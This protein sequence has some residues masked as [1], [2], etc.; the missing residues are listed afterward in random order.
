MFYPNAED[1]IL[2]RIE[3]NESEGVQ[4]LYRE[5]VRF[6]TNTLFSLP[7]HL[8]VGCTSLNSDV[9]NG[10]VYLQNLL[11]ADSTSDFPYRFLSRMEPVE[12]IITL[13]TVCQFVTA[14]Y[15]PDNVERLD[16]TIGGDTFSWFADYDTRTLQ[17][18]LDAEKGQMD[19]LRRELRQLP[20]L[21]ANVTFVGNPKSITI[22]GASYSRVEMVYPFLYVASAVYH[23]IELRTSPSEILFVECAD[24][25]FVD[26]MLN[27]D[28]PRMFMIV[29]HKRKRLQPAFNIS[30]M[31]GRR[32]V[33][34]V[35]QELQLLNILD[36]RC[37]YKDKGHARSLY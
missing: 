16:M 9:S 14:F 7:V 33:F 10:V 11:A 32:Y 4:A 30:G 8:D 3:G 23:R 24:G 19:A 29:D 12:G 2:K 31:I 20:Q 25:D 6:A 28:Q 22:A 27:P 18:L 15:V 36:D 34:P 21:C 13:S 5:D 1:E 37:A 26:K 35:P 17:E